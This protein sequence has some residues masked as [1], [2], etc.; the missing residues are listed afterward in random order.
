MHIQPQ[1]VEGVWRCLE[2]ILFVVMAA[3]SKAVG[4]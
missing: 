4:G 3:S 1:K 2:H